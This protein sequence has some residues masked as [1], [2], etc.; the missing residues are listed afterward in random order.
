MRDEG[1]ERLRHEINRAK[2]NQKRARMAESFVSFITN[3]E[4]G[5]DFWIWFKTIS[6]FE[7]SA[8]SA[9]DN[10]NPH[11]A[12]FRDGMRE[13]FNQVLGLVEEHNNKKNHE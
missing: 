2:E 11:G 8:F 9:R 3:S 7:H 12:A 6:G 5:M 13:T 10:F 1:K 4:G